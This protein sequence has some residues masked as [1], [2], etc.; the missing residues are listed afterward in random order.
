[1]SRAPRRFRQLAAGLA[2]CAILI[3]AFVAGCG[4]DDETTA[5]PTP[6]A[7]TTTEPTPGTT[8]SET[9]QTTTETDTN[10]SGGVEPTD[11]EPTET[12]TDGGVAPTP[13][14][15]DQP[16]SQDN[17][18]PPEPGSPAEAFENYCRQHPGACG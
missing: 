10:D 7:N 5:T 11:Q 12:E 6:A 14:D 18:L 3:G 2:L 8:S 4:G 16:D 15:P 13:A 9:T 17:D 1:V